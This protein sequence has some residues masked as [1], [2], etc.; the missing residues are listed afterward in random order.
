MDTLVAPAT[1]AGRGA[2]AV[3][4]L[5]GPEA[6]SIAQLLCP[7]G[8]EWRPRRAQLRRVRAGAVPGAT[9]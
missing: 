6:L 2:M 4:R 9:A 1:P 7:G 3:V 5:S 8:P